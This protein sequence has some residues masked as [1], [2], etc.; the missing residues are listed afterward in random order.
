MI[1]PKR[2]FKCNFS[3]S[4]RIILKFSYILY[5][6]RIVIKGDFVKL[7]PIKMYSTERTSLSYIILKDQIENLKNI[8]L[9][10]LEHGDETLQLL[11]LEDMDLQLADM[12]ELLITGEHALLIC[13]LG[14]ITHS[15]DN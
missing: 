1:N 10:N 14:Q 2:I 4:Y 3:N 12:I 9:R 11:E 7:D 5:L 13:C 15:L 6:F 8:W